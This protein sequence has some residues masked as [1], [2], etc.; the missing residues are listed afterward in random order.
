MHSNEK[1]QRCFF[2]KNYIFSTE[3]REKMNGKNNSNTP[4]TVLKKRDGKRRKN[5]KKQSEKNAFF[6]IKSHVFE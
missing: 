1:I 4:K 2:L 5:L 6:L 3:N